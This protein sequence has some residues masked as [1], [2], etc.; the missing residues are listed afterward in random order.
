MHQENAQSGSDSANEVPQ[1]EVVPKD[2]DRR[3][4]GMSQLLLVL[5]GPVDM[6]ALVLG[7]CEKVTNQIPKINCRL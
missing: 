2:L 4:N 5:G 7:T 3:W 6:R 1:R